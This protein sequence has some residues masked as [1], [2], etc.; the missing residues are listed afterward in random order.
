MGDG[1]SNMVVCIECLDEQRITLY[2]SEHCA[3]ENLG[4]HRQAKHGVKTAAEEVQSLV[5]PLNQAVESILE[6][7]NPGLKLSLMN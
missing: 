4:S 1:V 7:K 3:V 6:A 2:C 5:T